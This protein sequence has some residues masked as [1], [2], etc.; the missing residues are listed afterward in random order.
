MYRLTLTV[1]RDHSERTCLDT[2]RRQV[3]KITLKA[4]V[5]AQ[6]WNWKSEFELTDPI[7]M[8]RGWRRGS[9]IRSSA[10]GTPAKPG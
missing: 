7:S 3:R 6:A 9:S 4:L 10:G 5:S 2:R 8:Q 1:V